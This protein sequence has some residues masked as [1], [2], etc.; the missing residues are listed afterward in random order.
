[1]LLASRTIAKNFLANLEDLKD[2]RTN[3]DEAYA[4]SLVERIDS[5]IDNYL[6]MDKRKELKEATE[7]VTQSQFSV[8][9][10][11]NFIKIQIKVDLP[12]EAQKILQRLGYARHGEAV[13]N[14]D[15]ES[16][17]E[18]LFVFK[19]E[20]TEKLKTKICSKGINPEIIERI[21]EYSEQIKRLNTIQES[22]KNTAK[23]VTGNVKDTFNEIYN[24]VVGICKIVQSYYQLEPLK[25]EQFVFSG[26]VDNMN[27][28]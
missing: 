18:M 25:Q 3:W 2:L 12:E 16:L 7:N 14:K 5:I 19:K 17:I 15:Q 26:I 13:I 9:R 24:E 27:Q 4:G 28:N 6:G 11:L 1:M 8:I 22:L 23:L 20:M 21:I 10:D